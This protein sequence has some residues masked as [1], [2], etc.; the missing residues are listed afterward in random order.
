MKRRVVFLV[1]MVALFPSLLSASSGGRRVIVADVVAIDCPIVMNRFGALMP[2]GMIYALRRDVVDAYSKRSEAEGATLIPGRVVLR[3]DKRPRPINLRMNKGDILRIKF[4]NLLAPHPSDDQPTT[5]T[6]SIHVIGLEPVDSIRDD[7]SNVGNNPSSLVPP[8]GRITYDLFAERQGVFGI[9]SYGAVAGGDGDHGAIGHGLFGV[10]NV[11]PPTAEYY[12]SQVSR[13]EI[14]MATIGRTPDGHPIIDYDAVYPPGHRFEGLPILK[15]LH[16]NELVHSDL[17]AII[18]GP[19]RGFFPEGIFPEVEIIAPDINGL[20]RTRREP[21]R[22]FSIIFHDQIES[23]QAF[24]E[25]RDPVLGYTLSNA[26]DQF[27]I[28]YGSGGIGAEVLA[29]RKEIGPAADCTDCKYEEFFLSSWP[30]GDPALLV[31]IPV[32]ARINPHTGEP[33]KRKKATKALYPDDPSNVFHSYIID[34]VKIRNIHIGREHHIFHLHAQQWLYNPDDDESNYLDCQTVGPGGAGYTYEIAYN[35][36][37]NRNQVVG[38]SIFHCHFYP[39]FAQ[40]MWAHWRSHDVF[41]EG[42]EIDEKGIPKEG[43]R[44]LPDGEIEAGTPIPAIVPLPHLPMPPMPGKVAIEKGQIVVKEP[45]K[46]PGFPFF[47]PSLAGHRPPQPPLDMAF[48]A[49]LPRKIAIAKGESIHHE[50]RLDFLKE[51]L[52]L[53]SLELPQEG[54]KVEQTAM[55]YHAVRTHDSFFPDGT[56]ATGEKGFITNGLPPAPGAPYSD[57][58]IDLDGN[59]AGN[60]ATLKIVS[61][62]LEMILNKVGWHEQI[63][64]MFSL[65][66]DWKPTVEG[67]KPPIPLTARV[68]SDDCITVH[69]ANLIPNHYDLDD[70]EVRSPTDTIGQH[71]HLVKFDVTS[72]DGAGNGFNYEDGTFGPEE[73]RE[74]INAINAAGGIITPDGY[75]RR[76]LQPIDHPFFK[77][78]TQ[79]T[80]QKWYADPVFDNKGRDRTLNLVFTHDH[81]GPAAHQQAGLFGAIIVEPQGTVW[82]DPETGKIFGTRPDGGPTDWHA[83]ILFPQEP[84]KSFREFVLQFGDFMSPYEADANFRPVVQ[85]GE[86]IGKFATEDAINPPRKEDI[87]LPFLLAKARVCP[88]GVSAPCPEAV[89][90]FDPG[91]F[92][93]NYRNEPVSLRVMDLSDPYQLKQAEGLAGD[94]SFVYR[95]DIKR[96]IDALNHQ[97]DFYPPLSAGLFPGDPFT[98]LLR[99]YQGDRVHLRVLVGAHEEM[100]NTTVHGVRWLFERD[101][102]NSGFEN[103]RFMGI[104]EQFLFEVPISDS[105]NKLGPFADHLYK[106]AS[107][108]DAQ[109]DGVWGILRAYETFRNDLLALPNNPREKIDMRERER[110]ENLH[111]FNGVCPK[112]APLRKFDV[113]AIQAL[114]GLPEGTLIYNPRVGEYPG[115]PGPLNDPS[116]I[117]YVRTEDLDEHGNL[118]AEAPREP[119]ILRVN[120]GDC[121]EVTLRNNLPGK[122]FDFD[123]FSMLPLQIEKF[124]NNQILPSSHVG[125]HPQLVAYDVT[126]FD[127]TNVG[128]NARIQTAPPGGEVHYR[129]Y[130]G[131]VREQGRRLV[132]TPVEFGAANLMP[133]DPIKHPNKGAIGTLI[134]EPKGSRWVEDR[135]T[136]SQATVYTE[137][138]KKFR[139]FVLMFQDAI[140]LVDANGKPIENHAGEDDSEDSGRVAFNYRTEPFWFRL[141]FPPDADLNFRNRI[142][143]TNVLSNVITGGEDPATPV[144]L[145]SRGDEVRFRL[146]HPGGHNRNNVFSVHGHM[147]DRMPWIKHSKV[148]SRRRFSPT[149][150]AM[151]GFGPS[152]HFNALLRNGA[153]GQFGVEGDYLYRNHTSNRFV[154]GLW[155][156]MRVF[157]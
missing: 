48:D 84:Q 155:G 21:F 66:D 24:P 138:G 33:L 92:E 49:G 64:R 86:V 145:A 99:V 157:R 3:P 31:D 98:P 97:P 45:D 123:G 90:G 152:M 141:G 124:N 78:P 104:C 120:A 9:I 79:E 55:A 38:D 34:H 19:N 56:P 150:G 77:E 108:V 71:I 8:G 129:W 59:P 42:T 20:P 60:P 93:V 119:L 154:Q 26:R 128:L 156:I 102:E 100:F 76:K 5:R 112:S 14:E 118:K 117:L 25:F 142:D 80:I 67:R 68:H 53:P 44:A 63:G 96:K 82:R 41:E 131:I 146:L 127:G 11:E 17:S 85:D 149:I 113:T 70:F 65:W 151:E 7:G 88:G 130:A 50:N 39:H 28:N 51:V 16:G 13:E 148:L 2:G 89:S 15:M 54:T 125:L 23:V 29:N 35:G 4:Q 74:L 47:I 27:P 139:D 40:G 22:E 140:N 52:K 87:G 75:G 114:H 133:S 69:H 57:P 94:L 72:S 136:R 43:A 135:G 37:G 36:T 61:F 58:C 10:L 121:I 101:A 126:R 137:D 116:A 147:W 95:S 144:F 46:N 143:Y 153:G 83:D 132:A 81:F 1:L 107:S 134:I 73:V 62:Q 30:N 110:Y 109:W 106:I 103:S 91:V 18:T 105:V 12:R 111:E 115:H 32:A 122:V 6:A